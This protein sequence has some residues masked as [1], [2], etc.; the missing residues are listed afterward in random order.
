MEGRCRRIE[1]AIYGRTEK[2]RL[3]EA[4]ARVHAAPGRPLRVVAVEALRGG[5][6]QEAFYSTRWE[7]S[8]EEVLTWYTARWSIE[9]TFRD[10]KQ[11]LGFEEPQGWTRKAVKR[12]APMAMLLYSLI[13]LWFA[14]EGHRDY[15]PLDGQWYRSKTDPSFADMLATLR[16]VSLRRTIFAKGLSGRGS[17]KIRQLLESLFS[18]AA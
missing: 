2:A 14:Q 10:S 16:R 12:T 17:R 15:R 3:A 13:V 6:G 1:F 4:C 5:R 7:A 11:H 9:V 18:V 8:A